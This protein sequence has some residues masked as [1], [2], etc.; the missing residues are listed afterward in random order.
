MHPVSVLLNVLGQL[1]VFIL[2]LAVLLFWNCI[3]ANVHTAVSLGKYNDDD[4]KTHKMI[5]KDAIQ[6]V[7][8]TMDVLSLFIS[9]LCHSD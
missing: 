8:H 6:R 5:Q 3:R 2:D 7:G 4:D 1:L 9:V